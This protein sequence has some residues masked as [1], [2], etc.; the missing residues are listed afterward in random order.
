[1]AQKTRV[2]VYKQLAIGRDIMVTVFAQL[3]EQ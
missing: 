3:Y 2:S 1:M